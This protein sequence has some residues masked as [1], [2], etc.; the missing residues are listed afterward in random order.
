MACALLWQC[1]S[2]LPAA[3]KQGRGSVPLL[4]SVCNL[5]AVCRACRYMVKLLVTAQ[6]GGQVSSSKQTIDNVIDVPAC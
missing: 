6:A 3:T 2:Q 5:C 4:L 1:R